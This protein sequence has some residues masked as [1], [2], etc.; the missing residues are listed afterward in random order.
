MPTN[1]ICHIRN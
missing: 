1:K